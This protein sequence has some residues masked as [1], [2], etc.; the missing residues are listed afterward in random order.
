M[1]EYCAAIDLGTNTARLLIAK[2]SLGGLIPAHVERVVVR[3][4]GGFTDEYGLSDDAQ[5]RALLCLQR[6]SDLINDYRVEKVIASATSAVRDAV[7]GADFVTNVFNRTGIN[8]MVIDGNR[9]AVLT[10]KGVLSG[11]D[12][13]FDT[14]ILLDVGG[15]STEFTVSSK[16]MP[17]F[18]KSMPIGVVRLTEGFSTVSLMKERI[19]DIIDQLESE[20]LSSGIDLSGGKEFIGTAGTATTVAA[21]KLEMSNY[22]YRKVNNLKICRGDIEEIYQ[23]LSRLSPSERLLI[24]GVEKGRED[25]IIAG[26]LIISAVMDKFGF[27]YMKVSDFGLLEGLALSLN[28]SAAND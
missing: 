10:F 2:H 7:N 18:I 8:L 4:G 9:E 14:L 6:F 16:G 25:L 1:N 17:V 3:L 23:H 28:E 26:M 19:R 22:D 11:I 12:S 21:I 5:E 24:K 13:D 15:G 27:E 20:L